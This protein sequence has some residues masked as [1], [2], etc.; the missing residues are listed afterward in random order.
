MD[1]DL[2]EAGSGSCEVSIGGVLRR[3]VL[4]RH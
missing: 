1:P 3:K 4:L 2:P